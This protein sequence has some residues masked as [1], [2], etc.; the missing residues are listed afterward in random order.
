MKF[1]RLRICIFFCEGFFEAAVPPFLLC[2][3]A[4]EQDRS[5]KTWTDSKRIRRVKWG[6]LTGKLIRD[7]ALMIRCF[8]V[9][10]SLHFFVLP[11]SALNGWNV[12][13]SYNN[14]RPEVFTAKGSFLVAALPQRFLLCFAGM[15]VAVRHSEQDFSPFWDWRSFVP[16][17]VWCRFHLHYAL[18]S[19]FNYFSS[20]IFFIDSSGRTPGL[21]RCVSP[22]CGLAFNACI[23]EFSQCLAWVW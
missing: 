22:L 10:A 12:L 2:A 1:V 3:V 6:K 4:E 16:S 17:R 5:K 8:R 23:C 14:Q 7:G 18:Q 15:D 11:L 13:K 19:Y 20:T 21:L 9:T